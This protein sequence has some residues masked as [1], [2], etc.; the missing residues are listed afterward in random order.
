MSATSS[1]NWPAIVRRVRALYDDDARFGRGHRAVLRRARTI[2]EMLSEGAYWYLVSAAEVPDALKSRLAP[3]VLCFPAAKAS[4][5]GSF[6]LGRWLRNEIYAE[7]LE[8]DLPTRATRFR[9]LLAV[10]NGDREGLAHQLRKLIHH[11]AQK[12]NAVVDWGIVGADI[13]GFGERVRQKWA[14]DFFAGS[15]RSARSHNVEEV[16]HG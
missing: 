14:A 12:S 6:S 2:D 1:P 3:V 8:A 13:L 4:A 10:R 16:S 7:T 11:A 9:R 15:P 5:A